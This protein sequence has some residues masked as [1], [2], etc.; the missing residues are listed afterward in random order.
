MEY[1]LLTE[2]DIELMGGFTDDRNTRYGEEDLRRFL[3]S[4]NAYGYV[5][6]DGSR[7]EGFACAYVLQ[8]PDGRKDMYLHSIDIME[9]YQGRGYGTEL[10]RYIISHSRSI[11]CE[12]LFL[13]TD[14]SNA[15][16]CRCYE[17][18][19][20]AIKGVNNVIYEF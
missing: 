14:L 20:G 13:I 6:R 4:P 15:S 9:G 17:K 3:D 5:V 7:I 11:G 19:G 18:A 8:R 10:V 12:K 16:A 2:K 1:G